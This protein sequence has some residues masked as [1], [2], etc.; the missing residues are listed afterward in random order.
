MTILAK[1]KLPRKRCV[2]LG[3]TPAPWGTRVQTVF[4]QKQHVARVGFISASCAIQHV[5]PRAT[6]DMKR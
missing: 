5:E 6:T 4:T 1:D 2:K 3:S